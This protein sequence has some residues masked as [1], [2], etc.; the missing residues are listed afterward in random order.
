MAE[1][2]VPWSDDRKA[3]AKAAHQ[4]H[5]NRL[6]KAWPLEDEDGLAKELGRLD[7]LFGV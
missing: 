2:F 6:L 7:A 4:V 3:E 5:Y 1:L